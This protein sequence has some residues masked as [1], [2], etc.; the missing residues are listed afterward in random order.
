ML[1]FMLIIQ[2][3]I[4]LLLVGA[5]Y[6]QHRAAAFIFIWFLLYVDTLKIQTIMGWIQ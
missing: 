6:I 2:Y 1:A 3:F 5:V 4:A